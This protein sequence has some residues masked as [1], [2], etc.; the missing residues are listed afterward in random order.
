M[1]RITE[2][3]A[4][5]AEMNPDHIAIIDGQ[6]RITYQDW[7]E[8]VRL[9]AQWLQQTAHEQKRVAFYYQMVLLFSKYLLALLLQGGQLSRLIRDGA[10]KNV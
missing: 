8:R 10:M 4:S 5:H 2:C 9:S 7:Y 1:N 6:E 3:Y